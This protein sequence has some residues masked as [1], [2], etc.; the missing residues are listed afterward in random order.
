[1]RKLSIGL[2]IVMVVITFGAS[3]SF[4]ED[5]NNE[6]QSQSRVVDVTET[7]P[8]G[9][10]PDPTINYS[11]N[12]WT[13]TLSLQN[14]QSTGTQILAHYRGTVSC[15]GTCPIPTTSKNE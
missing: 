15:I 5:G 7:Y 9:T 1:M 14:Y 8:L 6:A 3:Q 11:Q 10:V 2:M 13:G 4:A 12:G